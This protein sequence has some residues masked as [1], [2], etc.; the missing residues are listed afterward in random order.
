[1]TH[2]PDVCRLLR[3]ATEPARKKEKTMTKLN[4]S[5]ITRAQIEALR[6]EAA[7]AGDTRQVEWCDAAL[8]P[9]GGLGAR[10]TARQVCADAINDAR[11]NA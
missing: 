2:V 9:L 5:T 4:P 3:R 10:D 8:M 6:S 1:M 11:A 7:E